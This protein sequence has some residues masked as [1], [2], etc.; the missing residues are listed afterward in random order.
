MYTEFLSF[1]RDFAWGTAT[2]SYQIEGA[3]NEDGRGK[4]IWDTFSHIKGNTADGETGDI[5]CDHYRRYQEDVR[6]MRGLGIKNYRCSI[7]WPRIIPSGNGASSRCGVSGNV[8]QKGLDFYDRLFD[9][10][11]ENGITPW[12]TLFH[13]D[14]PQT[15]QDKG[16]FANRDCAGYFCDY[17]DK[18]TSHFGDRIKNWITINEPWVYSFCGHLYGVHA[19]GVR[20]TGAALS[21]AHNVLLAHGMSLPIIRKNVP[22]AKAGIANNIAW[23]ESAGS[24]QEDTEAAKRWDMAFNRW[25]TDPLFGKGYPEEM[26]RWY[27]KNM[28]GIKDGDFDHI[29]CPMDFLAV[30][31]YTRRLVAHDETDSHIKAK[32]VYRP[33]IQ[34]QEFEEWENFPEGLYRALVDIKERY[35]D[36][37]VY[38]TENGASCHDKISGDGCVHDPA[39]VEYLRRHFAAA[40]QAIKDGCDLRG[41]FVWS[42]YDNLEWGFGFTKRFGFVYIDRENNLKRIVKDSGH[43]IASVYEKNGFTVD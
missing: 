1:P 4:S 36:I 30:N 23:V 27:G 13:W 26:V 8:N 2:A 24:R 40:W 17:T 31:Y 19:P 34:R 25:F 5:A 22:G 37:P 3:V 9:G 43:F 15:L 33:H 29:A 18:V 16:G 32:Q 39:R 41:Y 28:P 11:L 42:L 21:V 7:A 12:V 35:G 38:I 10:C 20:D 6:L 14:L